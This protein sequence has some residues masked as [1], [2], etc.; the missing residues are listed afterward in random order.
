MSRKNLLSSAVR[1]IVVHCSFT[2]PNTDI[3]AREIDR[4]HRRLGLFSNGYHKVICRDGDIEDGRSLS[5]IGAHAPGFN[6][7]SIGVCLVGGANLNGNPSNNFTD[8]QLQS[9]EE[10]LYELL[11]VF[12]FATVVGHNELDDGE[13]CP[14]FNVKRWLKTTDLGV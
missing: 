12:P 10:L 11:D 13:T 3:G 1:Y 4:E 2:D 8:A 6:S 14:S 7:E 9:L 5:T